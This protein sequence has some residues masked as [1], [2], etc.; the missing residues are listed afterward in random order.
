MINM[1]SINQKYAFYTAGA[2]QIAYPP[3]YQSIGSF[4]AKFAADHDGSSK[5]IANIVSAI[6]SMC[7]LIPVP[8]LSEDSQRQLRKIVKQIKRNDGVAISRK[9][10]MTM[11]IIKKS[12]QN[13]WH[14]QSSSTDMLA[15]TISLVGHNCLFRGQ[16]TFSGI[17][18]KD[19]NWNLVQ[20][21]VCI[22]IGSPEKPGKVAQ[23]G[24]GYDVSIADFAG[25]SAYKYLKCWFNAY[26]L[27]GQKFL[28]I[29]PR[30]IHSTTSREAQMIFTE[31]T[32]K[33]WYERQLSLMLTGLGYDPYSFS[34]HSHR[35]G[36][37]TDLFAAGLTLAE[38]MKH[39]RWRTDT[40]LIYFRDKDRLVFKGCICIWLR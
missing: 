39:G 3:T 29:F 12:L 27:W 34:V 35:A 40:A 36:G 37:A 1:K 15:A 21:I 7:H 20:R 22:H 13:Y 8:W 31:P 30:V 11:M 2:E 16:E 25:P 23:S 24:S 18:V 10:P 38:V 4:I 19:V 26:D 6:K 5:S 9:E 14:W 32:S 17:Q 28:Y 33:K